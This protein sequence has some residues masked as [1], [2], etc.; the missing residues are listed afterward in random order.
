MPR[1]N[2]RDSNIQSLFINIADTTNSI[3][4]GKDLFL[5]MNSSKERILPHFSFS[6]N[7][8]LKFFIR[9]CDGE[10]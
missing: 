5:K 9:L 1:E 2:S 4:F 7:Y 6:G 10:G 3:E 8:I